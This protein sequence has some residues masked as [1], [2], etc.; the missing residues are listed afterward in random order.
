MTVTEW[1]A[2]P[3][4][5]L[6]RGLDR[7]L[8]APGPGK[9][10][11]ELALAALG[12][13]AGWWLY[14]PVHEL[15]HALG[16]LAAGGSVSRLEIATLYGG[17]LLERVVPF[18]A[19]GSDYAGRLAGF[20]S[21]ESDAVYLATVFAPYLLTL[22]PGVWALRRAGRAGRPFVFGLTLPVALAPFVALPGDAYEIGSILT[23]RLPPW[24]AFAET[25]RGDDVVLQIAELGRVAGA[26]WGGFAVASLLG[27]LWAFATYGAAAAVAS[28]LREP[29]PPPA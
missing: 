10:Y 21:G 11:R 5:D 25:L 12:L 26:P 24:T 18:V 2:A 9:G 17:R 6:V 28:M 16:C 1:G 20:D 8:A 23:T 15:L 13:A 19:A 3:V 22:F 4:R 7:C 27:V 14:V 29:S